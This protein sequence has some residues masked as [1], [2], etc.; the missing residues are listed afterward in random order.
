MFGS[1]MRIGVRVV[2]LLYPVTAAAFLLAACG[3]VS[4]TFAQSAPVAQPPPTQGAISSTATASARASRVPVRLTAFADAPITPVSIATPELVQWVNRI[5]RREIPT[6]YQDDR[7][8]GKQK[9]VWDGLEWRREGWRLETKRRKKLVNSGTWTRYALDLVDP[10]QNLEIR[11]EKLVAQPDGDIDFELIV[12]SP[13]DVW[14]R[15]S[16]WVRDVQ[17]ISLSAEADAACRLRVEG[18]IG[19]QINPL[20]LPP[21]VKLTPRVHAAGIDLTYYRVRRVSQV[22]GDFAK[23]L[24]VGMRGFLDEK[25]DDL[26]RKLVDKINTQ[27]DKHADRWTLSVQDWLQDKLQRP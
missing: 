3:V 15:M 22:G 14:G 23:Y 17:I 9:E 11:F 21:E 13:L 26:N 4:Q 5:V 12:E 24:G 7:K 16:H 20:R 10:D 27:I 1:R 2:G 19:V 18:T 8:W 25:I 6:H